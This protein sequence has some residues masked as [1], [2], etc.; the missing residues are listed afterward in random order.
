MR[1]S[2][3]YIF[4][5]VR[6]LQLRD[7]LVLIVDSKTHHVVPRVTIDFSEGI[8]GVSPLLDGIQDSSFQMTIKN[9]QL[10]NLNSTRHSTYAF[11]C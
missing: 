3:Q 11:H 4:H 7:S 5:A 9:R 2:V 10:I 6:A 8:I 1:K